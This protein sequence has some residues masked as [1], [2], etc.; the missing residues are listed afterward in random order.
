MTIKSSLI[1]GKA[2]LGVWGCGYIGLTTMI[3][4]A[5]QGV[6][7][8]GYDI[9]KD[10]IQSLSKGE[11]P[12]PNLEY[13]LGYKPSAVLNGMAMFTPDWQD[14]M[15]KDVKVHLIAIPTEKNGEPWFEPLKDVMAKISKRHPNGSPDLIIIESTLTPG[16]FDK[17]VVKILEDVGLEIGKDVCV[18]HAPRRDWFDSPEKNMK[19]LPRVIG[20]TNQE[21]V[22]TI[23]E[24]LGIVCDKLIPVPDVHVVEMVKSVENSILHV[25]A[26]YACQLASAYPDVDVAEVLRLASTHWRIPLYYPSVGTG[27]YCIPVSSKYVKGGATYPEALR[28]TDEVLNSDQSQPFRIASLMV[29][30]NRGGAIGILGLSYKRDLKVHT[31]SPVLGIVKG[32]KEL[33]ATVKVYDPYYTSEEIQRIVGVDS[34]AYPEDLGEFGGLIIVPQHRVFSQ[35][36]KTELFKYLKRGQAI[37]DNEGIWSKWRDDFVAAGIDYHR[38]GDKGWCIC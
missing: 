32:L 19:S 28:I 27:G 16:M 31:L 26:T 11:V 3:N 15:C 2:R 18:G 6:Y 10:I 33:N 8:V 23:K 4:F 20:G 34:F 14:M 5:A 13:W 29:G 24:V 22:D 25:C 36:P 30:K 38:V 21:T 12:I 37:L 17:V 1:D 35:T 9:N 7:C